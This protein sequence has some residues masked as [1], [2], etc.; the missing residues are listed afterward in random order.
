MKKDNE[1][2]WWDL[3]KQER[4][5]Q[6]EEAIAWYLSQEGELTDIRK[7]LLRDAIGHTFRG[8]FGMARQDIY[9]LGLPESSWAPLPRE[10]M[11]LEGIT[12]DALIRALDALR[13]SP[14]QE[15]PVFV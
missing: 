6:I 1:P 9:E 2:H 13:A 8:L 11:M 12:K 14:V 5:E 7:M 3:S 4:K 15:R 10:A